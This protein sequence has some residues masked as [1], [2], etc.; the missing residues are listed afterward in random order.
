MLI[1]HEDSL[2]KCSHVAGTKSLC[3]RNMTQQDSEL[4]FQILNA[5]PANAMLFC[6]QISESV[7]IWLP[8]SRDP[9]KLEVQT[10][11]SMTET[12]KSL[13][14]Y[15]WAI[16]SHVLTQHQEVKL[17]NSTVIQQNCKVVSMTAYW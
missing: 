6:G 8:V 17:S 10:D 1:V 4:S 2:I 12:I 15:T 5:F 16:C 7:Q 11:H 9:L 13:L 3:E 14:G